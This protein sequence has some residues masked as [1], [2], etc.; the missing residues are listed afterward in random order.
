MRLDSYLFYPAKL[1]TEPKVT[2]LVSSEWQRKQ[3]QAQV[4]I[5]THICRVES[6][7]SRNQWQ[8]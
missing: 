2:V 8:N 3:D 7:F 4:S 5:S 6:Y 1:S